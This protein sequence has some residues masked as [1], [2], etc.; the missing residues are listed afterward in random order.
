M[1][2][3][4]KVTQLAGGRVSVQTQFGLNLK[5]MLFLRPSLFKV[6]EA[7]GLSEIQ[8]LIVTD[9]LSG[10]PVSGSIFS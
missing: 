10:H 3:L 2:E 7:R 1:S 9:Q 8:K 4:P 5:V 6:R